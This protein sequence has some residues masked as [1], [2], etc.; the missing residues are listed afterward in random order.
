MK[1]ESKVLL[2]LVYYNIILLQVLLQASSTHREDYSMQVPFIYHGMYFNITLYIKQLQ[3]HSMLE[4]YAL[5]D[6]TPLQVS[7]SKIIGSK[8]LAPFTIMVFQGHA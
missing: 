5:D 6:H 4:A 1:A 8:T 7:H 2:I 3:Q